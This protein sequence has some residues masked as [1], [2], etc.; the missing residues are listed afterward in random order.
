MLKTAAVFNASGVSAA[1]R[2][3]KIAS[4]FAV[5]GGAA[6]RSRRLAVTSRNALAQR[7][8]RA[9]RA[10]MGSDAAARRGVLDRRRGRVQIPECAGR[11]ATVEERS[12]SP[13][14]NRV[15]Q[16]ARFSFVNLIHRDRT[17]GAL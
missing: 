5:G 10:A 16:R 15:A 2:I 12:A 13:S 17:L 1:V 7:R 14:R 8:C 3:G 6:P 4:K 11:A 9:R